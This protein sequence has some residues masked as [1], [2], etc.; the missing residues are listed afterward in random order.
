MAREPLDLTLTIDDPDVLTW[1]DEFEEADRPAKA[2]TALRIGV[3][4][5]RQASGF[6]DRQAIK[7]EG[8]L[9]T[10]QME[11]QVREAVAQLVGPESQL[12]LRLD[13]Q[14]ADGIIAQLST[15]VEAELAEHGGQITG[16]FDLNDPASPLSRLV[17]HVRGSQEAVR[18]QFSLDDE[19]SGMSRVLAK[20]TGTLEAHEKVNAEFRE[21][22]RLTLEGMAIRKTA[23]ARGTVHG[24]EFED[25]LV[26]YLSR[27]AEGACDIATAT[28]AT[29]GIIKS[30]KVGDCVLEIGPEN[31]AAGVKI[32]FEA[33][34]AGGYTV[35]GALEE[36]DRARRNR[37]AQVG[38]F[39]FSART[40]PPG[41]APLQRFGK[42][43][44]V[45]WDAEDAATDVYLDAAV[46][47][48]KALALDCHRASMP[49]ID[50]DFTAIDKAIETIAKRAERT[51][52]VRRYAE[53]IQSN[54]GKI[55]KEM[56][57]MER[58][59]TQEVDRLRA[60]LLTAREA[61]ARGVQ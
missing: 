15:A 10:A 59:L 9:L 53:T 21:Q 24:L 60:L 20:L 13:P 30:E 36:I 50:V 7:D 40:V 42:D 56:E 2:A 29:T 44:I 48:A 35:A 25:A 47:L 43:V 58:A 11:K 1:L 46:T 33:K 39:V 16:A 3:L 54:G 57:V 32:V 27:H 49:E 23:D 61:L 8:T 34:Q 26:Q 38:V 6:V 41:V 37:G 5:L 45:V 14:R 22:V 52:D 28:G 17:E 12:M 4:A 31:A 18:Q 51:D 55:V 19:S